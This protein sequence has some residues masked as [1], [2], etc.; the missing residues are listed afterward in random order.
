MKEELGDKSGIA[1]TLGQLG[2]IYAEREEL[3]L[4][5]QAYLT[6]FSIFK[7]LNSPYVQLATND[8]A[9]LRNKMGEEEFDAEL[10]RLVN[11]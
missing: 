6:A 9:E 10:E 2:R 5:L 8:L 3:S 11:E 4:A 1:S 7:S